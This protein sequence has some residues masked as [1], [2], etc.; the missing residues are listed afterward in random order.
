MSTTTMG[1][2]ESEMM[3]APPPA[4]ARWVHDRE[5]FGP[6]AAAFE[7]LLANDLGKLYGIAFRILRNREDAED[8]LQEALWNAYRHLPLFEGRSSLSTWLTRIV[9]NSALMTLR[10][11]KSHPENSLDE[12][13]GNRPETLALHAADQRPNPEQIC[14]VDELMQQ[15][16]S[17][18][19]R[20]PAPEQAAFRHS[21]LNG[22]SMK[23]SALTFGA[24]TATF[25]SRILR[26]RRKLALGMPGLPKNAR[27]PESMEK[28]IHDIQQ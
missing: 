6:N 11:R 2:L 21:V 3:I 18:L 1:Q 17:R 7:R 23:E 13:M 4:G 5:A 25:K 16:E 27:D 22:H 8:A 12:L 15:M 14:A 26:T 28:P 9:I 24:P 20:L 19:S 10:R